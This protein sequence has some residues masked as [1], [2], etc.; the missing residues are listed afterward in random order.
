MAQLYQFSNSSNWQFVWSGDFTAPSLEFA[1][2]NNRSATI[3]DFTMPVTI[4]NNVVAVLVTSDS[5]PGTWRRGG[6]LKQKI[7]TGI[8]DGAV[9]DSYLTQEFLQ[10]RRINIIQLQRINGEFALEF[11]VPRW[12]KQV[13]VSVW[14]YTGT[15][16]D[17]VEQQF[18]DLQAFISQ[19]CDEL[20]QLSESGNDSVV[21]SSQQILDRLT[22][23]EVILS[24]IQSAV[25][26]GSS[27][28][29]SNFDAISN[30]IT[31]VQDSISNLGNLDFDT[32]QLETQIAQQNS[33]LQ[34]SLNTAINQ[35]N[36]L[37]PLDQQVEVSSNNNSTALENEFI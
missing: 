35:L 13:S 24:A 1:V 18:S 30:Q 17:T 11:A 16:A 22:S 5:D 28:G 3:P 7:N 15:V 36:N 6:Y 25:G 19:C 29:N 12:F 14:Q 2:L 4:T 21:A 32:S 31:T 34:S 8:A 33:Q 20:K 9:I 27:S 26:A 23:S 37:L 10:L